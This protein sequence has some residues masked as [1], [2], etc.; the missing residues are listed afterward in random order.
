MLTT[1]S[2]FS[3]YPSFTQCVVKLCQCVYSSL[4]S[5]MPFVMMWW[6][7][8]WIPLR[9]MLISNKL[10]ELNVVCYVAISL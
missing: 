8:I 10:F 1:A 3:C 2:S 5:I 9:L 7:P 6:L 4:R